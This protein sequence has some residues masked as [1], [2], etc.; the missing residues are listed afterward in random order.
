MAKAERRQKDEAMAAYMKEHPHSYPDS[1]MRPWNGC[2]SE[3]RAEALKMGRV[4]SNGAHYERGLLGGVLA[5]KLG[6]KSDMIAAI[7]S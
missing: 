1:V 3:A 5:H 7:I 2:G 4:A 6:F